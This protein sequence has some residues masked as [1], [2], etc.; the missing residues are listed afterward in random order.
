MKVV[1]GTNPLS[2]GDIFDGPTLFIAGSRSDFVSP[3][4]IH[5]LQKY[6]PAVELTFLP[7]G[8]N[9]H[10]QAPEEFT[11]VFVDWAKKL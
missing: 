9:V 7:T 5:L 1:A 8:H 3:A 6:F 4:D 10:A 2:E 11:K